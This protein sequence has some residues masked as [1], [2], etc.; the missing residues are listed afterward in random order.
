MTHK[1]TDQFGFLFWLKWILWFAGSLILASVIWSLLIKAVFGTVRGKELTL[2]WAVSVFGSWFLLLIPFMRKKEQIWKRLNYDQEKAVD[3]WLGAMN[4]FI[5]LFV[6]SCFFWSFYYRA[7]ITAEHSS[8]D[9]GWLKAVLVTWLAILM[10]V[11]VLLYRKADAIF[12]SA[13]IRQT[14]TGTHFHTVF[15]ERKTRTLPERL[16]QKL[17]LA[18][19]TLQDGH[20][21]TVTLKDGRVVPHVFVKGG[22][23]ILGVYDRLTLG[24]TADDISEITP[25]K[26][27]EIPPYEEHKWLRLDGRA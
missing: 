24:F 26:L 9:F 3:A 14:Q 10:P 17:K 5:G 27:E 15:M 6:A 16:V 25:M 11:L 18:E 2:L 7:R 22:T 8:V 20:V 19:P 4:L 21:T 13:T 1:T 23:E 12:K